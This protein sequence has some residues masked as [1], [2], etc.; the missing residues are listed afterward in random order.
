MAFD[1]FGFDMIVCFV[2]E[3][4]V[5]VLFAIL[6]WFVTFGLLCCCFACSLFVGVDTR[7]V[8]CGLFT[9]YFRLTF[10]CFGDSGVL[11]V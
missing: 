8:L 11:I 5:I 7:Y 1:Y 2:F 3:V 9:W 4:L 10:D 6:Q